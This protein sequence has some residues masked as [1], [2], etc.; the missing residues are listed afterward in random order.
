MISETYI[1]GLGMSLAAAE[2]HGAGRCPASS[3]KGVP[4]ALVQRFVPTTEWHITGRYERRTPFYDPA[5]V[6]ALFGLE[7]RVDVAPM[8]EAVAALAAWKAS[9]AAR[10][11]HAGCH[12][13]WLEWAGAP[14]RPTCKH[15]SA[16]ACSVTVK[17]QTA[18]VVFQ[19]GSMMKK[20]LNTRGFSFTSLIE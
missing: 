20:R 11:T 18:L 2:A 1:D 8:I 14:H 16:D 13:E 12:V 17:G 5:R 9:H 15:R 7:S 19:D 4:A 3:I 6:R 10:T